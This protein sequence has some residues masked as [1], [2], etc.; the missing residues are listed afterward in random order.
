[1]NR[2]LTFLVI[3]LVLI[4]GILY[5]FYS[6]Q[7][8]KA[9]QDLNTIPVITKNQTIEK[10]KLEDL[11]KTNATVPET[12]KQ[13][14]EIPKPNQHP[15]YAS[16]EQKLQALSKPEL[17][18]GTL[19][20]AKQPMAEFALLDTASNPF[21][22]S[23]FK[24]QWTILFFGYADCPDVCPRSLAVAADLFKKITPEAQKPR[25]VFVTLNPKQDT[26]DNLKSFLN[27]FN[28]DFIGLTGSAAEISK[29]AQYCRVYHLEDPTPN[30][31]GK[32]VIDH[33]A[34]FIL[35]NPKG[36]LQALFSPPHNS[37]EIAKD[38]K[39]LMKSQVN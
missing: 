32:K 17:T 34:A 7:K 22:P 29:L 15:H 26:V 10:A 12:S 14:A 25:L 11:S 23:N 36:Q 21:G 19:F 39:I 37:V 18:A 5:F 9:D 2:R 1:M 38:L 33:T 6:N 16:R 13:T 4:I 3:G 24:G 20:T 28:Q 30:S 35:I 8:I 31:Q 27:K